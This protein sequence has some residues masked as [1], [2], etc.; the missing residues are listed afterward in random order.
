LAGEL[1]TL[2]NGQTKL[3]E[4]LIVGDSL[5]S[6]NINGL[7]VDESDL[8]EFNTPFVDYIDEYTTASVVNIKVDTYTSYYNINNDAL[9][10]TYEH[11]VLVKTVANEVRFK[12]TKDVAVG[13]KML[14]ENNEWIDV[15]SIVKVTP[16][17][18][19]VTYSLDIEDYDV[20]F[21]NGYLVHN[22]VFAKEEEFSNPL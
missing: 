11:P 2:A 10:I 15:T 7:G 21:A 22:L 13:D 20:Y 16:T 8:L 4:E 1:I 19:F 9:K 12:I 17:E 5:L 18:S 14:N 6:L 3:I